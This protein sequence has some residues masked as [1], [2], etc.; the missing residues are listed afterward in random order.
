MK[1]ELLNRFERNQNNISYE[2]QQKNVK[3]FLIKP[4]KT[5]FK[6]SSLVQLKSVELTIN[7]TSLKE[8]K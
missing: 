1:V 4:C 2:E 8:I 7:F 5:T 6:V 3:K